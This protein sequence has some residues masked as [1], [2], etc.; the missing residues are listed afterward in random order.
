M[1]IVPRLS[2]RLSISHT[3]RM[4]DMPTVRIR[5]DWPGESRLGGLAMALAQAATNEPHKCAKREQTVEMTKIQEEIKTERLRQDAEW[6][7]STHDDVHEPEKWCGFL[8]HQLRLADRAA[9]SL[10]IDEVTGGEE[11]ALIDGYRERLIKIAV[12][13][14]AAT[15]SL[16]R[17]MEKRAGPSEHRRRIGET[18]HWARES[19][20]AKVT[21]WG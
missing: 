8:R 16:D 3:I 17:M 1:L 7:G 13:A 4:Y 5:W 15:E 9:C 21:Q 6:G 11:Q 14:I 2:S 10:A 20:A 12:V 18:V 19:E